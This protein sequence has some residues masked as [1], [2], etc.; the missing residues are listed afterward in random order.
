M[1]SEIPVRSADIVV[2]SIPLLLAQ[3]PLNPIDLDIPA[4]AYS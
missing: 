1:A 3:L 2:R 4:Y